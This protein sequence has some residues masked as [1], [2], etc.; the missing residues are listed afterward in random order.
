M[1]GSMQVSSEVVPRRLRRRFLETASAKW[2]VPDDRCIALPLA[3][4][5]KRFLVPLWVLILVFTLLAMKFRSFY[6]YNR[7]LSLSGNPAI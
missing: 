5:R 4:S 3:L 6:R 1:V 7:I 2:L